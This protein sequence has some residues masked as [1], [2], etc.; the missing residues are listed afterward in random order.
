M[1]P[2]SRFVE[3]DCFGIHQELKR[4]GVTLQLLWA[5]HVSAH[6]A[7]AYRYSQYCHRYRLWH[8]QQRRSRRQIH[9]AGEKT[10]IDYCS[11]T[12]LVVCR[13]TGEIR[14]AQV[15]VAVLGASS[16]DYAEATWSQGLLD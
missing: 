8:Q 15:F 5:E 9:R 13:Q 7:A 16:Y 1:Q 11:P 10:F 14:T 2:P 6:E 3:P 12:V 4:K